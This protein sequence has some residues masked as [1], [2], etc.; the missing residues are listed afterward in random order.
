MLIIPL[1]KELAIKPH[2]LAAP[3]G[4]KGVLLMLWVA[5]KS[6]FFLI[7]SHRPNPPTDLTDPANY[8]ASFD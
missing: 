8:S 4:S 3:S 7:G 1:K 6:L 2:G 5:F